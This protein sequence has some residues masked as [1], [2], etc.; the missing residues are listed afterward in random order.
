MDATLIKAS[1]AKDDKIRLTF[2]VPRQSVTV[3]I[4]EYVDK[5]VD[6]KI[7]DAQK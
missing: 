5:I 1:S 4:F 3:D 6:I 2:D 7:S